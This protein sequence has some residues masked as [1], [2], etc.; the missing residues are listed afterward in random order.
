MKNTFTLAIHPAQSWLGHPNQNL[1][2]RV[3]IANHVWDRFGHD[4]NAFTSVVYLDQVMFMLSESPFFAQMWTLPKSCT[5]LHRLG[6]SGPPSQAEH[7][8]LTRDRKFLWYCSKYIYECCQSSKYHQINWLNNSGLL[9]LL[10]LMARVS[11]LIRDA[12]SGRVIFFWF[13]CPW[14]SWIVT[15]LVRRYTLVKPNKPMLKCMY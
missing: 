12:S 13:I 2:D 11:H 14:W 4:W 15:M 9:D 1:S 3:N 7:W 5:L 6:A 10:F 8:N